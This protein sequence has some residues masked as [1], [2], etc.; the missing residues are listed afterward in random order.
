[1]FN[2][3]DN[4]FMSRALALA[5]RGRY[6]ARPNPMVGAVLVKAGHS[7]GE[8]YHAACGQAHA[9]VMALQQ[10]E[11][12]PRGAVCYVTLEP[13]AHHGRTP[14]CVEAL[15]KAG[16]ARVVVAMLDPNPLVAG[17]GV[18]ALRAHGIEVDVGLLADDAMALN[19]GYVLRHTRHRPLVMA[20]IA[21]SLDG[22]TAMASGESQWITSPASRERVQELRAESGAI[23][24]SINTVLADNPRLTVR[25]ESVFRACPQGT[26]FHQP[27]R[28]L[29]DRQGR[30]SKTAAIFSEEAP[31]WH[32]TG[33]QDLA[34][35]LDEL[36]V[37]E[38]NQVLIEAG[39]QLVGAFLAGG[40]VDELLLFYAPKLLGH[41]GKPMA[42]FPQIETL[43][44]TYH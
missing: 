42:I 8:G 39:P 12:Q 38:V 34:A 23:L 29:L 13:C 19:A 43:D 11:V 15:I 40:L 32:V 3:V 1:M 41:E 21:M 18:E 17:K 22:R 16:V 31:T 33:Q 25:S 14:P 30:A 26:A 20:K 9:E 44:N 2:E 36:A 6:T 24:T 4:A 35:I 10:A 27:K 28:V 37:S 7:I 5:A